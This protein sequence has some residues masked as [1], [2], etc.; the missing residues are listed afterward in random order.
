MLAREA[1][2]GGCALQTQ[3]SGELEHDLAPSPVLTPDGIFRREA[4]EGV[5]VLEVSEPNEGVGGARHARH[6]EG[7]VLDHLHQLGAGALVLESAQRDG[8][9]AANQPS[10]VLEA[11]PQEGEGSR[12]L[13]I[14]EE[15]DQCD[16]PRGI[17]VAALQAGE[18]GWGG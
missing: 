18:D 4:E 5:R 6:F 2:S 7:G 10:P 14:P 3:V 13:K 1:K 12:V 11:T 8:A 15:I 16:V 9:A 17:W